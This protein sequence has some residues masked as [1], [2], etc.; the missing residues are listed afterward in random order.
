MA[1]DGSR[2]LRP[3]RVVCASPS[4]LSGADLLQVEE[5]DL[6]CLSTEKEPA[7]HQDVTVSSGSE[8][9]LSCS[10][11]GNNPHTTETTGETKTANECTSSL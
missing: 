11:K 7:L 1:F 3:W 9:L 5:D 10:T 6:H 4:A 2:G 8:V